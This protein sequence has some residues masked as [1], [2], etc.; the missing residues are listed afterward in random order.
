MQC[1]EKTK[2]KVQSEHQIIFTQ[3]LYYWLKVMFVLHFGWFDGTCR[4]YIYLRLMDEQKARIEAQ[5]DMIRAFK[6]GI[7]TT[8]LEEIS[9]RMTYHH[10]L[11]QPYSI[12]IQYATWKILG[13]LLL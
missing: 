1:F 13:M 8:F 9:S 3:I 11:S 5:K 4:C 2:E 6:D 7:K 12:I 10:L